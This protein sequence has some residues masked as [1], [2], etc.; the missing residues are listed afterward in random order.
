[1]FLARG[2]HEHL[3]KGAGGEKLLRRKAMKALN[4]AIGQEVEWVHPHRLR[5]EY[6][7]RA[8]D[9]LFA[10]LS[11]K[12]AFP[13]SVQAETS[14]GT[15]VI[16]RKGLRQTITLRLLG[17][18]SAP[19]SLKRGGSGQATLRFPDGR[20]YT[21]QCT[22]GWHGVWAWHTPEGTTLLHLTRGRQVHLEPAARDLPELAI[23]AVLGWYLQ[24]QQEEEAA[25]VA[26]IVPIIGA[27]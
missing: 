10:R 7:L 1:V 27:L 8:G 6:E 18:H 22:S 19:P 2:H 26:V 15:W 16:E 13:A 4:D 24:K 21:W 25:F 5:S 12:G 3:L 14:E 17:A 9:E 11:W 23:L 20:A